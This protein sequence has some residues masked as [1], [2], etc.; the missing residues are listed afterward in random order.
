MFVEGKVLSEFLAKLIERT[1]KMV[2][3]DPNN[4]ETTVGATISHQ[5]GSKVMNFIHGAVK[6]VRCSIGTVAEF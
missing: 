2:I 5:H 1:K 4:E 6:E 3:G